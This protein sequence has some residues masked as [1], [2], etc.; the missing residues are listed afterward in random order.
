MSIFFRYSDGE[1]SQSKDPKDD[2]SNDA[3]T[4][5]DAESTGDDGGALAYGYD[6][7]GDVLLDEDLEECKDEEDDDDDDDDGIDE[8]MKDFIVPDEEAAGE[9]EDYDSEQEDEDDVE[10]EGVLESATPLVKKQL[11]NKGRSDG[12]YARYYTPPAP[13]SDDEESDAKDID[14]SRDVVGKKGKIY[15]LRRRILTTCGDLNAKH[16]LPST[17]R[18]FSLLSLLQVRTK[19][20][21]MKKNWTKTNSTTKIVG[22]RR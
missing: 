15:P 9:E 12:K 20:M 1:E 4:E 10:D 11:S 2:E 21:K 14:D 22:R 13:Q 18:C 17:Y 19:T 3:Y 6:D 16:L 5:A 8:E 7:E